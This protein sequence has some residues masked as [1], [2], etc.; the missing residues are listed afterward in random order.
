M[1]RV[2]D[3]IVIAAPV[4]KVHTFAAEPK[5]WATWYVG[6]A[7]PESIEGD[8]S[9]GTVVKHSYMML[10]MH[11]PVTTKVTEHK[12]NADGSWYW[13]ADIEGSL[14]GWQTWDYKPKD[15]GTLV[16]VELEY[17]VP[18]SVLGK[19]ADRL[20][21]ERSQERSLRHTLENLKQLAES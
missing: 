10:G 18:G 7:E 6:L 19:A 12:M 4:E 2:K 14:A 20:F 5:N 9:P 13:K 3:S 17:T 16:E 21:V 15:G 11:I 8:N 1:A